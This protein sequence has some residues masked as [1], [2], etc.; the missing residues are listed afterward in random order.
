[1]LRGKEMSSNDN[2][3]IR[4][5]KSFRL[6]SLRESINA[7]SSNIKINDAPR[8]FSQPSTTQSQ[9]S[10][11]SSSNNNTNSSSS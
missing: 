6:D 4:F 10:S 7:S 8:L 9:P 11:Q 3:L 1:M 2:N 5:Q